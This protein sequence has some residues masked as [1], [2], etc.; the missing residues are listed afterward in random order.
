MTLGKFP[1]DTYL[2][3]WLSRCEG[4]FLKGK[5]K[6]HCMLFDLEFRTPANNIV[7]LFTYKIVQGLGCETNLCSLSFRSS[8]G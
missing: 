8:K 6:R 5:D 3:K 7:S 2:T 1:L 4:A